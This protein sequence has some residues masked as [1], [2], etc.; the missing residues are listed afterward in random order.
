MG[1]ADRGNGQPIGLL[2]MRVVYCSNG[3]IWFHLLLSIA[4]IA[5]IFI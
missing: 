4:F 5:V 3:L 2:T 1:S